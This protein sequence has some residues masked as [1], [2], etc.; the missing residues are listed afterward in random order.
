MSLDWPLYFWRVGLF[1]DFSFNLCSISSLG[2]PVILDD[3]QA[4]TSILSFNSFINPPLSVFSNP[5][6]ISIPCSG[7]QSFITTSFVLACVSCG[8]GVV[9][10]SPST[11]N[12]SMDVPNGLL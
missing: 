12:V 7:Y 1:P 8:P 3:F 5:A 6:S 4:N 11:I 10:F 2:T 9:M